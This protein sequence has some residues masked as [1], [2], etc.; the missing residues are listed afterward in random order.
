MDVIHGVVLDLD[1]TLYLEREY[2]R[3]GFLE[4]ARLAGRAANV[5][6]SEVAE[7]LW[8]GFVGGVRGDAFDRLLRRF[9]VMQEH[10][11]L[12]DLVNAYRDHKPSIRLTRDAARFLDAAA[13]RGVRL[14][15]LTDGVL[16]SQR[17]KVGVLGLDAI[18][19]PIV[20]TDEWGRE[21]W[22][23]HVRGYELFAERWGVAPHHLV[24]V[25]DNPE[26]DF[27][28]PRRMGW[29]T[30]R[31]RRR[32]QLRFTLEP[33]SSAYAPHFEINSL[34]SLTDFLAP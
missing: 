15:V 7:N 18:C 8:G 14:G 9:P 1:D 17:A 30:I 11:M 3:S 34:C 10:H 22:K 12:E 27:I 25:G 33:Q 2:V 20:Y 21:Y 23:P 13:G 29:T 6:V 28:T 32:G 19:D 16:Q 5:P 31:L 24:Y 26:K 4:V